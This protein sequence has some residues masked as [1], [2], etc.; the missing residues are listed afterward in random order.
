MSRPYHYLDQALHQEGYTWEYEDCRIRYSPSGYGL[1]P[2]ATYRGGT[3]GFYFATL[4]EAMTHLK[5]ETPP[6]KWQHP[7]GLLP[8][9]LKATQ[10]VKPICHGAPGHLA[11][12]Q[13]IEIWRSE[14]PEAFHKALTADK[15]VYKAWDDLL[16]YLG[17]DGWCLEY[18]TEAEGGAWLREL[19]N[20]LAPGQETLY[21][22]IR[23]D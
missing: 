16:F 17:E 12:W 23:D 7:A 1:V 19:T 10:E 21:V 15:H 8:E 2:Y 13:V 6:Y 5:P 9:N 22:C 20:R 11:T 4:Y 14:V 18:S 3:S